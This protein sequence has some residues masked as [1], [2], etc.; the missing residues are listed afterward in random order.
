MPQKTASPTA[1]NVLA[2]CLNYLAGAL[3]LL[4]AIATLARWDN[5]EYTPR[6]YGYFYLALSVVFILV[7]TSFIVSRK[8]K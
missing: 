4:N 3:Y 5:F 7:G 6:S 1:A 8:A 2:C